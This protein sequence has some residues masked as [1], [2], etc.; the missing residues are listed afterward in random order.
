MLQS[1]RKSNLIFK[2]F[3]ILQ[4]P[5]EHLTPMAFKSAEV[6]RVVGQKPP[7]KKKTNKKPPKQVR[8]EKAHSARFARNRGR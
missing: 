2:R 1:K 7:D 6:Q 4:S 5:K 8:V 3:T